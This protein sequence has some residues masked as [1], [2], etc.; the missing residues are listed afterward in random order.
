M[1]VVY[2]ETTVVGSIA[3][4]MHP[5]PNVAFRSWTRPTRLKDCL[6]C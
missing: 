3:G 4:R 1:D 5:D 6:S 2:I